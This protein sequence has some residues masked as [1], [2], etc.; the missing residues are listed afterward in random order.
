M[1]EV[2]RGRGCIDGTMIFCCHKQH[3]RAPTTTTIITKLVAEYHFFN[4]LKQHTSGYGSFDY[5]D[6]GYESSDIVKV[7]CMYGKRMVDHLRRR[8]IAAAKTTMTTTTT[9]TRP[10]YPYAYAYDQMEVRLKEKPVDALTKL[11]H[12]DK[13]SLGFMLAGCLSD[14]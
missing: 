9:T 12:R 14:V 13:G 7:G 1:G 4:E 5:E 10:R 3:H 6:G 11:V 2:W 8:T